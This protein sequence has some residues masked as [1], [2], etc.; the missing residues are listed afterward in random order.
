MDPENMLLQTS[1][2]HMLQGM[3]VF[4]ELEKQWPIFH[5]KVRSAMYTFLVHRR[6]QVRSQNAWLHVEPFVAQF[7]P[8]SAAELKHISQV[9]AAHKE[10]KI[11]SLLE[12]VQFVHVRHMPLG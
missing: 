10:Q 1:F 3:C 6:H 11:H 7:L 2:I 8:F 4:D 5:Q 12:Q 9:Q